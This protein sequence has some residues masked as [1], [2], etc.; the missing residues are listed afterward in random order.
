[1]SLRSP[2]GRVIGRETTAEDV[3]HR[4]GPR[5]ELYLVRNPE[6]GQWL[7]N[8]HGTDVPATGEPVSLSVN[9]EPLSNKEP[10]AEI[11]ISTNRRTLTVDAAASVDLDG[12]V[13]DVLWEFGDGATAVG[14]HATHVYDR[15]GDYLVTVAVKDDKGAMGFAEQAVS[16]SEYEFEGF[17]P[18]VDNQPTTNNMQAGRAVPI[19]FRLGGD[20]GLDILDPG[21]P[22][23]GRLG[24]EDGDLLDEVE[25]TVSAGGSQLSYDPGSDVYS[26]VWKTEGAW[27]GSCRRFIL[28]L[29]D[30]T[31]HVAD[32]KFRK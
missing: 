29:D 11:A 19:K 12:Q 31:R 27:A 16:V 10:I 8:L 20:K 32:F 15:A 14:S 21:Y 22:T 24:C 7:V 26:Y 18:P 5:Q 13:V 23:V 3:F 6:P 28:Q 9:E 4:V 1:M 25:E 30:G 17:L 2:S